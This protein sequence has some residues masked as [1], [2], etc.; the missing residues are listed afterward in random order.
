MSSGIG[1][2][3]C[4]GMAT[5]FAEG[6]GPVDADA[7]RVAAQMPPARPAIA[8]MAADD[9]AFARNTLADLVFGDRRAE[10]GDGADEFVAGHHRHRHRLLCP[11]VPV[12]D[13]DVGAADRGLAGS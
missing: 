11:L 8:A 10:I 4:C 3:L 6:A 9:V 1:T 2:T 13:V 5:I 7:E 12:V